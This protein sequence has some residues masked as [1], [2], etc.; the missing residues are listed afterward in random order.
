MIK[1]II[2]YIHWFLLFPIIF[3][4]DYKFISKSL[5]IS[6]YL[7]ILYN[8]YV[9]KLI[10]CIFN[11]Y[12]YYNFYAHVSLSWEQMRKYSFN[13]RKYIYFDSVMLFLISFLIMPYIWHYYKQYNFVVYYA[14]LLLLFFPSITII[15]SN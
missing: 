4:L 2:I 9:S 6:L 14:N 15:A 3:L 13:I 8:L 1:T 10:N 7:S 11:I 5:F 12:E